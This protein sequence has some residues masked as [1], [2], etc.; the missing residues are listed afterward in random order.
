[1]QHT[2]QEEF[3]AF[4]QAFEQ[5]PPTSIRLNHKKLFAQ[6]SNLQPVKWSESGFYLPERPVFAL[7]PHWHAGSYYVQE[8]SSM[9]LE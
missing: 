9:F 8:A 4:L 1:M 7:D 6:N 3:P 2:L 5:N